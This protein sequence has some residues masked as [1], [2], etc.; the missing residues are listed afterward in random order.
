[1]IKSECGKTEIK[2]NAAS[3]MSD[4][5]V[6]I[7]AAYDAVREAINEDVAS[8]MVKDTL[9]LANNILVNERGAKSILNVES[10]VVLEYPDC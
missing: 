2:G 8:D 10:E 6:V 4:L 1:M 7:I 9:K 3:I 5:G